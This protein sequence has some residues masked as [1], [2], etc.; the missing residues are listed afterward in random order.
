MGF[1]ILSMSRFH[2][3]SETISEEAVH[4]SV[5]LNLFIMIISALRWVKVPI[6]HLESGFVLRT[7]FS[8]T[9]P[10]FIV[11]GNIGLNILLLL[12]FRKYSSF[13]SGIV[14][15]VL[16]YFLLGNTSVVL[17]SSFLFI[18]FMYHLNI[19]SKKLI[20]YGLLLLFLI[21]F[22]SLINWVVFVPLGLS[23]IF[24]QV[25][26]VEE[27]IYYL[28]SLFSPILVILFLFGWVLKRVIGWSVKGPLVQERTPRKV[29]RCIPVIGPRFVLVL[30]LFLSL[31]IPIYPYLSA[32]N[33]AREAVSPDLML[34]AGV[35]DAVRSDWTSIFREMGGSRPVYLMVVFILQSIF[36]L[37][38]VS[39]VMY[40]PILFFALLIFSMHYFVS[41]SLGKSDVAALSAFL[42][43][44]GASFLLGIYLY[45]L[46]NLLGLSLVYFSLGILFSSLKR[47][48]VWAGY[49]S[50]ALFFIVVFVHPWTFFQY[51][52]VVFLFLFLKLKE[53]RF[54]GYYRSLGFFFVVGLVLTLS[55]FFFLSGE[56]V[57]PSLNVL[58][59]SLFFDSF[60]AVNFVYAGVLSNVV[61]WLLSIYYL[62][63]Q[64]CEG[65]FSKF[66][67]LLVFSTSIV[68]FF[69]NP[70]D[71]ARV[72]SNLPVGCFA[73]LGLLKFVSEADSKNG[74]ML[75]LLIMVQSLVYVFRTL[76]FFV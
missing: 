14:V 76:Y 32:I 27:Q 51:C 44:T 42:L 30:A 56:S 69:L 2:I 59:L 62:S 19:D 65:D 63:V 16:S 60:K 52:L 18:Y 28:L 67:R 13:F 25:A 54:S 11:I 50:L 31:V 6:F 3:N 12:Y 1:L 21:E 15:C 17:V 39:F 36:R 26:V 23:S 46:S 45:N 29:L 5:V 4:A 20:F 37:E 22:F 49:F 73:A 57:Q 71:K 68:F 34:R 58:N 64:R 72:L 9:V 55:V 8:V 70:F 48:G 47:E 75:I 41:R 66:M 40:S 7:V 35:V 38:S 43:S 53:N 74:L 24:N 33:P 10:L 61:P